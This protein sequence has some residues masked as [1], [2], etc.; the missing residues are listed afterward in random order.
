MVLFIFFSD[1]PGRSLGWAKGALDKVCKVCYPYEKRR[2]GCGGLGLTDYEVQVSTLVCI[3]AAAA[4]ATHC[5]AERVRPRQPDDGS[6]ARRAHHDRG[7]TGRCWPRRLLGAG[8]G[9]VSRNA[10]RRTEPA[11]QRRH[12][13]SPAFPCALSRRAGRCRGRR[14][15]ADRGILG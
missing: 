5:A 4:A 3:S 10:R 1:A 14:E 6:D 15:G 2:A 7:R 8:V 11:Q 12:C 9:G 13:R